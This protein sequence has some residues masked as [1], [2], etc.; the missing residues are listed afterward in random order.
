MIKPTNDSLD[1]K[2]SS[3]P[4]RPL[5]G[6]V[7]RSCKPIIT[8]TPTTKSRTI[9][10]NPLLFQTCQLLNN[11]SIQSPSFRAVFNSLDPEAVCVKR[12]TIQDAGLGLFAK[13]TIEPKELIAFF[14]GD[15]CFTKSSGGNDS[16]SVDTHKIS[17]YRAAA[18]FDGLRFAKRWQRR[19]EADSNPADLALSSFVDEN[20]EEM[21]A[22]HSA[23]MINSSVP[24]KISP[25]AV[26][27]YQTI[28]PLCYEAAVF[29]K[30]SKT[31]PAGTEIFIKYPVRY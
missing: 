30:A 3:N 8:M 1:A 27:V 29:V 12:S 18:G 20:G 28:H 16:T 14:E 4:F 19:F 26:W 13:H 22:C 9:T 23:Y 7:K 6:D 15:P 17:P 24:T 25:N 11:P 2:V 5:Y 31:I 21:K 10:D